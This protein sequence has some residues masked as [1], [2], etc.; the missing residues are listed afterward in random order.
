MSINDAPS[1]EPRG[2]KFVLRAFRY[3]NYRLFFFGQG[4]SLIGTWMQWI[5]MP[6]LVWQL[7]GSYL[8]LGLIGFLGPIP[9]FLIAPFAGVVVERVNLRRMLILT[10][11]LAMLQAFTL[12]AL[13]LT[14]TIQA[15]QIIVL[16]MIGGVI[17]A[18]DMTGRQAFV[19]QMVERRADLSNAIALNSSMFNGAR[20]IGPGLAGV[21]LAFGSRLT[22]LVPATQHLLAHHPGEGLCLLLNGVSFLAVIGALVAMRVP[23]RE[24][25]PRRQVRQELVE[26]FRYSFGHPGIRAVLVLSLMT[27][28]LGSGWGTLMAPLV[29][30]VYHGGPQTLGLLMS[31]GAV[32]AISGALYLASRRTLRGLGT[33]MAGAGLLFGVAL[34]GFSRASTLALG[35]PLIVLMNLGMM[36]QGASSNTTLQTLVDDDKRGRVMSMYTMTMFAGGPVS[37]LLAGTL[38]GLF[39][40]PDTI[41]L[42]GF[43][44][45]LSAA[46][47]IVALART[48]DLKHPGHVDRELP[49]PEP[50]NGL[51]GPGEVVPP[52]E[53]DD[54]T[55]GA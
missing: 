44:V 38:A 18:F 16:S 12:T 35:I 31:A 2:W 50:P 34:L 39:G 49:P 20:L 19:I 28:L 7:Y 9:A 40:A 1:A 37:S 25:G 27:G 21:A 43:G 33:L 4:M 14:G 24:P 15:W 41:L 54:E 48:R 32:G 6:W 11:T 22:E 3:R 26:G 42:F 30:K 36:L 45:L 55:P 47:F 5:A 46:V 53:A 52:L 10:Q 51:A 13:V 29:D 17:G 8:L 23:P